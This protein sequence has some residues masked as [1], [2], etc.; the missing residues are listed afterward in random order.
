M[1]NIGL[2][3]A[4]QAEIPYVLKDKTDIYQIGDN[5]IRA[6]VSGIGPKKARHATRQVCSGFLGFLPD[7]LINAG[8]CGAVQNELD[9]GDLIIANHLVHYDR[10]IHIE[11]SLIEK[12]AGL[13]AGLKP[14]VGKVQTFNRPVLSRTR[15]TKDTIAVD[16]ESF[17]IAQI[18]VEYQ[19]PVIFIKAVSDIV[20][21]YASPGSLL[22]LLRNLKRNS[23]MV[24]TRLSSGI[25]KIFQAKSLM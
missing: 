7:I 17:A 2:I 13:L 11:S 24:Q 25:N 5:A 6:V 20:P 14:H 21:K 22:K 16:M 9:I 8:F 19:V 1:P 15:V 12:V 10:E 4:M 18:A 3:A 23:K